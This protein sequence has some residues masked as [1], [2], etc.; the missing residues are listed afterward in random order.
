MSGFDSSVIITT[1]SEPEKI[2]DS[3]VNTSAAE[4]SVSPSQ[5]MAVD[6]IEDQ[7]VTAGENDAET[8]NVVVSANQD[9]KKDLNDDDVNEAVEEIPKKTVPIRG[10]RSLRSKKQDKLL[11]A[12][13]AAATRQTRRSRRSEP[14][15]STEETDS[16]AAEEEAA[17]GT[18]RSRRSRKTKPPSRGVKRL[19]I[20]DVQDKE[21]Q[22][23][24]EVS[25]TEMGES[26]DV[27]SQSSAVPHTESDSQELPSESL[28]S[29]SEAETAPAASSAIARPLRGRATRGRKRKQESLENE[30]VVSGPP[31]RKS[32]R[33]EVGG[34]MTE[35]PHSAENEKDEDEKMFVNNPVG[36]S[37]EEDEDTEM[38]TTSPRVGRSRKAPID[39]DINQPDREAESTAE[40]TNLDQDVED[41]S[42]TVT[43]APDK[44]VTE[45]RTSRRQARK[46][47]QIPQETETA[48]SAASETEESTVTM[49]ENDTPEADKTTSNRRTRRS[50]PRNVSPATDKTA[51]HRQTRKSLEMHSQ[52]SDMSDSEQHINNNEMPE[53]DAP[54]DDNKPTDSQQSLII[55][56]KEITSDTLQGNERKTNRR[57]RNTR[58]SSASS[59]DAPVSTRVD[60]QSTQES[61]TLMT[62]EEVT[63]NRQTRSR[64]SPALHKLGA[65]TSDTSAVEDAE[66]TPQ[67]RRSRRSLPTSNEDTTMGD[68]QLSVE[69]DT[70][71]DSV[72]SRRTRKNKST[73]TAQEATEQLQESD[74]LTAEEEIEEEDS[75]T[76]QRRASRKIALVE[77]TA[78]VTKRVTRNRQKK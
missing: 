64:K 23:G 31:A 8:S 18:A 5:P 56:Q 45:M 62:T 76:P 10:G 14:A 52:E 58:I 78:S 72:S 3:S 49:Q 54:G 35:E 55:E 73:P 57:T 60:V 22:G 40:D 77:S 19:D 34:L 20:G 30:A 1:P 26:S 36:I 42:T 29:S 2:A 75:V 46:S 65:T 67:T 11:S 66:S 13:A 15:T 39:R 9:S 33:G 43:Q 27:L 51:S 41:S 4:H 38:A 74:Y 32:R 37:Q 63:S 28:P 47:A 50:A 69:P 71:D 53:S 48:V 17:A 70:P 16:T 61:D 44:P 25:D 59:E 12:P 6:I 7:D 24:L 68:V 21:E